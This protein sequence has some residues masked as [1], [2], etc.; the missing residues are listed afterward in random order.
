MNFKVE[1]IGGRLVI[2]RF[3]ASR[4]AWITEK[5]YRAETIENWDEINIEDADTIHISWGTV[6]LQDRATEREE[7]FQ[8]ENAL[9]VKPTIYNRELM[10][11]ALHKMKHEHDCNN[12]ITWETLDIYL[13]EYCKYPQPIY[14]ES[15][16]KVSD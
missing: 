6:D 11:N 4:N 7:Q 10:A 12:G 5:S 3:S 2:K 13:D 1:K 8:E 14:Y 15:N 16:G 9:E